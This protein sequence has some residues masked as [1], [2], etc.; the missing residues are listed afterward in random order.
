MAMQKYCIYNQ[1]RESF[2][3]LG[4]SIAE[5]TEEHADVLREH[6][7]I[8]AATGL[9]LLPY[10]GI[11]RSAELIPFDLLFLDRNYR[12]LQTVEFYPATDV[13]PAGSEV[14]SALAL[15]PQT[16]HTSQTKVGDQLVISPAEELDSH[17]DPAGHEHRRLHRTASP[18][19]AVAAPAPLPVSAPAAIGVD[20]TQASTEPDSSHSAHKARQMQ[21]A[22]RRLDER[23][24]AE[25]DDEDENA[26]FFSRFFRWLSSD[27]RKSKRYPLPGL[28]AYYWTGGAPQAFH[29]GDV[30]NS[31]IFLLTDERWFPGTMILMTLQRVDT[32]GDEPGDAIG[33]QT[34]VI[35]WDDDG[36]GLSFF[37]A[38]NVSSRSAESWSQRGVDQR[39]LERFL[40]SLNLH[41]IDRR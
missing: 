41:E 29:I 9:W 12:V 27:R 1:T 30:S 19:A 21:I 39:G 34:K 25:Q 36:V 31:G 33:V 5:P 22:L 3:S 37:P 35:R 18:P 15:P 24:K 13:K 17:F 40:V 11:S 4:V 6:L 7:P 2:L 28:V 32:S 8:T 16:I 20:E 10:K 26:S 14:V 38:R 23:D